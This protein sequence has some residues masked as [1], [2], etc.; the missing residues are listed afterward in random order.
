M[1]FRSQLLLRPAFAL[2]IDFAVENLQSRNSPAGFLHTFLQAPAAAHG[3]DGRH[4]RL[5]DGAQRSC[6]ADG[7]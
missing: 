1:E 6:D 7:S 2:L 5:G 4:G 3:M